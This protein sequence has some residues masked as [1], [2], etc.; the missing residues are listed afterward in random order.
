MTSNDK[1]KYAE[2]KKKLLAKG[3]RTSRNSDGTVKVWKASKYLGDIGLCGEFY[4]NSADLAD[5]YWK[6]QI[7]LIMQCIEETK[8]N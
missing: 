8:R 3:L 4:C 5:P 1:S 2:L 7:E 6:G